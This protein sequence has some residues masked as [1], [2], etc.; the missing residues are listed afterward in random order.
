MKDLYKKTIGALLVIGASFSLISCEHKPLYPKDNLFPRKV[1]VDIDWSALEPGDSAPDSIDIYFFNE[2]LKYFEKITIPN[3]GQ[4]HINSVTGGISYFI[5]FSHDG[6]Y[7]LTLNQEFIENIFLLNRFADINVNPIY[8]GYGVIDLMEGDPDNP[9]SITIKPVCLNQHVNIIITNGS[10]LDA[11]K[12]MNIVSFKGISDRFSFFGVPCPDSVPMM[13]SEFLDQ[14]GDGKRS[15]S[16]RVMQVYQG[17]EYR[18]LAYV[19]TVNSKAQIECYC[20]DVTKDIMEQL[21]NHEITIVI[22]FGSMKKLDPGDED[23][24]DEPFS[25]QGGFQ[26]D[27]DTFG[28]KGLTIIL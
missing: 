20:A 24:P 9:I 12:N 17:N 10:M 13:I 4:P 26:V 5:F 14:T 1:K 28:D 3:D 6:S 21:N 11:N 8:G 23:Y 25:I 15:G 2:L 22:D 19:I 16:F 7:D 27:I 18:Y